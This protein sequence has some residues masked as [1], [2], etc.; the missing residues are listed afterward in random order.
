MQIQL[1]SK[2]GIG[3]GPHSCAVISLLVECCMQALLAKVGNGWQSGDF[4]ARACSIA[5]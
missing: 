3:G 5:C 1:I 4:V 2:V